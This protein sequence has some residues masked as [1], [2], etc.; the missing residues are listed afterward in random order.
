MI[1][2]EEI[3]DISELIVNN[4]KPDKVI[5]FGSYAQGT[6]EERSDLDLLI[7]SDREKGLP[8]YKRGLKLRIKLAK[9]PFIKKDIIIYTHEELA[10]W[11]KVPNS[12]VNRVLTEGIELY[13]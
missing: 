8:R 5:L 7:I 13:G 6:A 4:Y 10:K 1:T 9:Y 2:T 3:S 11:A 12:F